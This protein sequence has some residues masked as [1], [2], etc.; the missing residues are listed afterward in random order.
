MGPSYVRELWERFYNTGRQPPEV[1]TRTRFN[2]VHF[3]Q[4]DC[5]VLELLP[6]IDNSVIPFFDTSLL[7]EHCP[8]CYW[9]S[10]A[11]TDLVDQQYRIDNVLEFDDNSINCQENRSIHFGKS[12][13][14]FDR[15]L[16]S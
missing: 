7:P 1:L 10:Y 9:P 4:Q 11:A 5:L 15:N 13:R 6:E 12:T 14:L 8:L 3:E 16:G 2:I